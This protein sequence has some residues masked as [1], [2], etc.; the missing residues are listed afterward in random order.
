MIGA[1]RRGSLFRL[2]SEWRLTLPA[3]WKWGWVSS[4]ACDSQDRLFVHSRSDHPLIVF[5]SGGKFL[6]SWGVGFLEPEQAHGVSV[7]SNDSVFCT[8]LS[9]C[10]YRF[11]AGGKL[12]MTVGTPGK[13]STADGA[14]FNKPTDAAEDEEG[15]VY[16]SD[17]YEN[18]CLHKFDRDGNLIDSWGE[19]GTG[20]GQFATVHCVR[21]DRYGRV[22][23]CDRENNRVQ[24]FDAEMRFIEQWTDLHRPCSLVF[25]DRE[26]IVCIAEI[27]HRVSI[28][29]LEGK[30][31]ECLGGSQDKGGL[32]S[33]YP[34]GICADG[35]GALYVSEV[36]VN[37]RVQKFLFAG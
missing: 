37:G 22:W 14:P 33:G 26:N 7:G 12:T 25:N 19:A 3:G 31:L 4:I 24:I 27:E 13:P 11:D 10:V 35:S 34:H 8:E 9:H 2:A 29:T 32:F 5:D 21:L 16:V 20:P 30:L 23:V 28:W 17:G 6:D 18:H 36:G 1:H 15:N